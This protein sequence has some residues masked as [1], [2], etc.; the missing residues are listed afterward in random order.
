MNIRSCNLSNPHQNRVQDKSRDW[1]D[2]DKMRNSVKLHCDRNNRSSQ[3]LRKDPLTIKFR[4]YKSNDFR[5]SMV[6]TTDPPRCRARHCPARGTGRGWGAAGATTTPT[7]AVR[8][9]TT[10]TTTATT[11]TAVGAQSTP[12]TATACGTGTGGARGGAELLTGGT[13]IGTPGTG[14]CPSAA[15]GMPRPPVRGRGTWTRGGGTWAPPTRAGQSASLPQSPEYLSLR[16]VLLFLLE[17]LRQRKT[18]DK[19]MEVF[20]F[21]VIQIYNRN[22]CSLFT[23]HCSILARL[24]FANVC[25][26]SGVQNKF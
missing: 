11:P 26:N 3:V 12:T 17:S 24:A 21:S 5:T 7:T 18:L 22:H 2:H 10:T 15:R 16:W 6:L 13:H 23:V 14:A 4:N 19:I 1:G 25:A 20:N 8:G 9:T